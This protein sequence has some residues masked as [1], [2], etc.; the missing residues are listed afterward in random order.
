[1]HFN[2]RIISLL[3][4]LAFPMASFAQPAKPGC[5][6]SYIQKSPSNRMES[7]LYLIRVPSTF[8]PKNV[9]VLATYKSISSQQ[10][11]THQCVFSDYSVG[12]KEGVC[13][14]LKTGRVTS[15]FYGDGIEIQADGNTIQ[16]TCSPAD[17][18]VFI[19]DSNSNRIAVSGTIARDLYQIHYGRHSAAWQVL[20][21]CSSGSIEAITLVNAFPGYAILQRAVET[22][23]VDTYKPAPGLQF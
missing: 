3:S 15:I 20:K 16:R 8:S 18:C 7:Q 12:Y 13:K 10:K 19:E 5:P 2:L 11:P 6:N 9:D 1:M 17:G 4:F 23:F 14:N 21:D 22:G